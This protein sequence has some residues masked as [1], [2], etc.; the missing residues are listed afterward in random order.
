MAIGLDRILLA[1]QGGDLASLV[2]GRI[3]DLAGAV[4]AL[5]GDNLEAAAVPGADGGHLFAEA[6]AGRRHSGS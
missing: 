4:D 5:V 6:I 1:D 2:A 3:D